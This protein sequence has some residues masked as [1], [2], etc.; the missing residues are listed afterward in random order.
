M[1]RGGECEAIACKEVLSS[2]VDQGLRSRRGDK[3]KT[4]GRVGDSRQ[5]FLGGDDPR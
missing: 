2:P 5:V 3:L 4:R 1:E